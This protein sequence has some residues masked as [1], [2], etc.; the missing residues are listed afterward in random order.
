MYALVLLSLY[1]LCMYL[2]KLKKNHT[3]VLNLSGAKYRM[4]HPCVRRT[5]VPDLT[6]SCMFKQ[7]LIF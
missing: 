3:V 5:Q 1:C 7:G 6:C 4:Q 2:V